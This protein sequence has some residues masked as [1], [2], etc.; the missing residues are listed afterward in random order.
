[1]TQRRYS[2]IFTAKTRWMVIVIGFIMIAVLDFTTHS[3]FVLAYLYIIPILIS[4]SFLKPDIAKALLGVAVLA[5]LLNLI[6]PNNVLNVPSVVINRSLAA[7]SIIISA[8]FMIRYIRYQHRIQ[9]QENL[10]L[11]ERNLAHIREDFI[12][13]LTHDLK[14]PLIG[15]QQ[16]LQYLLAGTFGNLT[17]TQQ[18]V[19]EA[20]QRSNKRQLDLVETL[21]T[22]YK[23]DNQGAELSLTLVDLDELIADILTEVQYLALDRQINLSYTCKRTPPS[24]KGDSLQLKRV[25]SNLM[26]N[27]LNYTPTGGSVQINLKEQARHILVEV[28]DTG[29]GI[30]PN[31]IDNIFTRFYQ[32]GEKRQLVGTGLGL[33]LSRQIILAH[34]GSIQVENTQPTGCRFRF[35]VPIAS[36][37]MQ[38]TK[39]MENLNE[40]D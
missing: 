24:V 10:L 38:L 29:P 27:A 16:T 32:S 6:F 34:R 23:I 31:D 33:Y 14:T 2:P 37:T 40:S 3:Q 9:E 19:L 21:V 8:F 11:T 36:E 20:L 12:A 28:S 26:H 30:S 1:M 7:L 39:S 17:D 18:K 5:T 35:T 25:I 15:G 4:V 13:T 22:S